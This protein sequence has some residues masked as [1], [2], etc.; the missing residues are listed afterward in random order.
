M[1][2]Y[3]FA[4]MT[5]PKSLSLRRRSLPLV[6]DNEV[7]IRVHFCGICGTDISVY[8]GTRSKDFPYSP[9][10][11]YTGVIESLRENVQRLTVGD[12]VTVNPNYICGNCYFCRCREYNL[13]EEADIRVSSNGGMA[14]YVSIDSNF[15]Y[16]LP[17]TVSNLTGT[18][19]ES[20]ACCLHALQGTI[21]RRRRLA[22][23]T[24]AG[25][26]GLLI[27]EA[28]RNFDLAES[29]LVSEPIACKRDIASRLGASITV[30]PI[31]ESLQQVVRQVSLHGADL[32]VECSGDPQAIQQ[33]L[34]ITRRGGEVILVGRPSEDV[35]LAGSPFVFARSEITLRG[36]TRFVPNDIERAIEWISDGKITVD[37]YIEDVFSLSSIKDAF[38]HA[39]DGD[40]V[41]TVIECT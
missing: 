8:R 30:N 40:T 12:R 24:G 33:A 22:V 41:K 19:I 25:T 16:K 31:T 35:T 38:E 14:E 34:Y 13:C 27:L 23:V 6:G 15:V 36:S 7:L 2:S 21:L 18:L 9:G 29:I 5:A 17:G 32:V 28:M 37:C 11:E 39:L 3:C 4:V 10:H 1:D 20:L 26:M